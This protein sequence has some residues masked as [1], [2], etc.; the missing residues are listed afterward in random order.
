[1]STP[2]SATLLGVEAPLSS[3]FLFEVDGVEIGLFASVRGLAVTSQTEE[4]VEGGQNGFARKLPGRLEW[5]NIV[6]SRGLTQSDAL[7]Q[8]MQRVS[9]EGFAANGNKVTRSTGAITAVANNGQRL[10]SWSL[11]GVI[12]VRWKGPDFDGDSESLLSE[13]LEIAHEGFR[14][15]DV[16]K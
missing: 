14:A 12:P 1:M 15:A 7:F 8:W 2:E 10:R 9:G 11:S 16:T 3:R 13:E 6:F 5:P 4:L